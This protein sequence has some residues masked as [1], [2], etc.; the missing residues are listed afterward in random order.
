MHVWHELVQ[1]LVF[2]R[3]HKSLP[4]ELSNFCTLLKF[5]KNDTSLSE[6][7]KDLINVDHS[8]E[9]AE[10]EQPFISTT[11][12]CFRCNETGHKAAH[13]RS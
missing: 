11:K 9:N 5:S 8:N 1:S 2:S 3:P 6:I 13:C 10:T 7:K 4:K 12:T